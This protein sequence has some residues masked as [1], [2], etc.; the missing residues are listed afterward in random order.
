MRKVLVVSFCLL[1]VFSSIALAKPATKG[2]SLADRKAQVGPTLLNLD[3]PLEMQGLEASAQADTFI[4][5]D[6][7]WDQAPLCVDHGWIKA[8]LTAQTGCYFHVD[9]DTVG[10]NGGDYGRLIP[11]EGHHSAWCGASPDAGDPDLCGYAYLP[12]YGNNWS[13][14]WYHHCIEVP[15]TEEVYIE[16]LVA[17]DSEPGFDYSYLEY[18]SKNTCDSVAD[19]DV[20][21]AAD[22]FELSTYTGTGLKTFVRDTIPA[23]HAGSIRIRFTFSADGGW[24]DQDGLWDTDGALIV[25]SVTVRSEEGTYSH[26]DNFEDEAAGDTQTND[27]AWECI[28]MAGY[29]SFAGLYPGVSLVQEDPCRSELSCMWA[30]INGSTATYACGGFPGQT[31][32]PYVNLRGQYIFSELWSPQIDHDPDGTYGSVYELY[33][34]TYWDH[35]LP[36][37]IFHVWH[38]R[39][40]IAGCPGEWK[41]E[42]FIY[43]GGGGTWGQSVRPVGQF[44]NPA[45]DAVQL[46][47]GCWD[48]CGYY[49]SP[50]WP[51]DC[52]SHTP[53][54]DR[55]SLRRIGTVGPVFSVRDINVWND[56]FPENGDSSGTAR[57]D[58]AIDVTTYL[59][60]SNVPGDSMDIKVSEPTVGLSEDPISG[61]GPAV[62]CYLSVN[63][64]RSITVAQ[65]EEDN[66]RWPMLDSLICDGRLW[67]MFRFDTSFTEPGGPRTG[68]VPD[69]FCIDVNDHYF[70]DGDT[71][72]FFF[73]ATDSTPS[74]T[75][76]SQNTGTVTV[77]EEACADPMEIQVLPGAGPRRGGDILY[78]DNFSG[79]GAEPYFNSAFELM[80]IMDQVD[81]FD[82]RGPSS[83]VGNGLAGRMWS[84]ANQLFPNYRKIIWNSG[85]LNRGTVGDMSANETDDFAMLYFFMD[86]HPD[87]V[88]AGI[89]FS[90]DNMASEWT[91]LTNPSS[92]QFINTY[93]PY[94][95]VDDDH[96]VSFSISPLVIG[97]NLGIFDHGVPLEEDTIV[98][99]GGCPGINDFD[100]IRPVASTTLE[101]T[102]G[103]SGA[104]NDGAVVA[105]DTLNALG[106]PTAVVLSGFS[107]H[108][109]RDDRPAGI[110]DRA[111]HLTDII[112]FLR[113]PLDDPTGAGGTPQFT[114]SLAQ[115][116]PNPFNPSTTIKYSI[117][118]RASVSLKIYNVAGQL[119]RTL[120]NEEKPAGE[121][122]KDWKG[123]NDAGNPVSSGVYFYKLVTKNFT[124]TKKMVLL[125]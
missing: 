92:S 66:L 71:L 90:G 56:T 60:G 22:W 124:Q 44:I 89:Y 34:W 110:P 67:Y 53:L 28:A 85:N 77:I 96:T 93:I 19:P 100:V 118:A 32:V 107:F 119:V 50:S 15:D 84:V 73:S 81:R 94:Q 114:N 103:G 64:Q 117:K 12:G 39:N 40:W 18:A 41:D 106:H 51:G 61:F 122:T 76:W 36:Q 30:W 52:H 16:Y 26:F 20:M 14:G 88:G 101:M 21:P 17:W 43:Y 111:D 24:S 97:E 47:I 68:P 59:D 1:F 8:D 82:K 55:V 95:L 49:C 3:L 29:G 112:R 115:N 80:G 113:N 65:G 102:Y 116:Y 123:R 46:A 105:Y 70:V 10:L 27:G 125:K 23:G 75:Y 120:V 25:D 99:Y 37:M 9:A 2:T 35:P 104:A 6:Y 83:L 33:Y 62:Y 31:A 4:L 38:I 74:T 86:Q 42:N 5:A 45:A 48:Y 58:A 63:P 78:V 54:S 11:L 57:I 98:A 13:Q 121:Y 108:Y 69:Q 109:I 7:T 87:P 79:R 91:T 72:L